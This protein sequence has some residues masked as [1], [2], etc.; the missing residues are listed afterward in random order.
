MPVA[1]ADYEL[2]R[3]EVDLWGSIFVVAKVTKDSEPEIDE[4]LEAVKK[5]ADKRDDSHASQ[6][7]S[8]GE[9]MDVWLSPIEGRKKASTLIKEKWDAGDLTLLQTE[10]FWE[11][12]KEAVNRPT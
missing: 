2:E 12:V 10:K 6:I 4:Q 11:G 3:T 5:R 9:R 8:F 7:E 1:I